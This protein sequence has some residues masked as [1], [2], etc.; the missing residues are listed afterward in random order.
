MHNRIIT[1]DV[2]EIGGMIILVVAGKL[3]QSL[4]FFLVS[5]VLI[6]IETQV[7]VG[8][9]FEHTIR[10]QEEIIVRSDV[11][12]VRESLPSHG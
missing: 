4:D 7:I 11:R 3:N 10:T 1:K 9:L 8:H 12:T 5:H 2:D 6:E